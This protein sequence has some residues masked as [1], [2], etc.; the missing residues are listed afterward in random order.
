MMVVVVVVVVVL[1]LVLSEMVAV[2]VVFW[3]SPFVSFWSQIDLVDAESGD[4]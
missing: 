3:M 2:V 4:A 1:V